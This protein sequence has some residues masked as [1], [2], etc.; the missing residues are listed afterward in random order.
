MAFEKKVVYNGSKESGVNLTVVLFIRKE[1]APKEEKK[2]NDPE[3]NACI[4]TKGGKLFTIEVGSFS[5]QKLDVY[6]EGEKLGT[7]PPHR[8]FQPT[9]S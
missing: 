4:I 7:I 5:G 2:P 1:K 9:R 6:F 3:A 8:Y